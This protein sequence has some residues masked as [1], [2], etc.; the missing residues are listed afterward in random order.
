MCVF[1]FFILLFKRECVYLFLF[2]LSVC[3]YARAC[4]CMY[5][6]ISCVCE[7]HRE[8]ECV[9]CSYLCFSVSRKCDRAPLYSS[10]FG[11]CNYS[12]L[13]LHV[14]IH[15]T[16]YSCLFV[17]VPSNTGIIR[18]LSAPTIIVKK[19]E[20][21]S[22]LTMH[23]TKKIKKEGSSATGDRWR[24]T[25]QINHRQQHNRYTALPV[26]PGGKAY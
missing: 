24:G 3:T 11:I 19:E 1:F 20:L 9:F 2:Y 5:I 26:T 25:Q 17:C 12:F 10:H 18:H 22:S 6:S 23:K 13:Y 21:E 7:T 14:C 15:V 4:V 8:R 16:S